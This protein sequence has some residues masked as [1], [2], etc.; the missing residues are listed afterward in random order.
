MT[1]DEFL[2]VLREWLGIKSNIKIEDY[3]IIHCCRKLPLSDL[4]DLLNK[5][6]LA[7]EE[8]KLRSDLA[9]L[10]NKERNHD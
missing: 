5:K 3:Y 8:K 9:D 10:M 2:E 6:Q 1:K 4:I 7:E